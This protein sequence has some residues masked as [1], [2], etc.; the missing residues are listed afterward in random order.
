MFYGSEY[1][2]NIKEDWLLE[3]YYHSTR[4][5]LFKNWSNFVLLSFDLSG[6]SK[7]KKQSIVKKYSKRPPVKNIY[8]QLQKYNVEIHDINSYCAW[9]CF[10]MGFIAT[11]KYKCRLLAERIFGLPSLFIHTS[12]KN[13][14]VYHELLLH[15]KQYMTKLQFTTPRP[16]TYKDVHVYTESFPMD[17]RPC[18]ESTQRSVYMFYPVDGYES[19]AEER[20]WIIPT[21]LRKIKADL[22]YPITFDPFKL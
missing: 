6:L 19:I 16:K 7:L 10:R 12:L 17:I 5:E 13:N 3:R 1:I 11:T 9:I 21:Y 15:Q 18:F 22:P 4:H 20:K 2:L 8:S 14:P